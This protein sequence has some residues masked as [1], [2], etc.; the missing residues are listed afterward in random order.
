MKKETHFHK[1]NSHLVYRP[2]YPPQNTY[3]RALHIIMF[4]NRTVSR[5]QAPSP[6]HRCG[7]VNPPLPLHL[8][9]W[10]TL[11]C[12][13]KR[14]TLLEI[15]TCLFSLRDDMQQTFL[16]HPLPCYRPTIPSP[17]RRQLAAS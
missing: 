5:I 17:Q 4:L 11:G 1:S 6:R 2:T 3:V 10:R 7:S 14:D 15:A 16:Y 12:T 13:L 9:S 8:A